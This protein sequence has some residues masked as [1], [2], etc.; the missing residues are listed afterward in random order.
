MCIRDSPKTNGDELDRYEAEL[1][2]KIPP[3]LRDLWT[4]CSSWAPKRNG[5]EATFLLLPNPSGG[6]K[7]RIALF[8]GFCSPTEDFAIDWLNEKFDIEPKRV[9]AFGFNGSSSIFLNYDNDPT[10][11]NPEVWD[12]YMEG[13][14][15]TESWRLVASDIGTFFSNL[16]TKKEVMELGVSFPS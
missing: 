16:K 14:T 12:S 8:Y 3:V 15:L 2:I 11:A 13:A 10:G 5:E 6:A 1:E 9:L 4:S 7:N